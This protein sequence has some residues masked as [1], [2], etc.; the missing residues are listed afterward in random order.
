MSPVSFSD[1]DS[2]VG[3]LASWRS[4]AT[5]GW[6]GAVPILNPE[7]PLMSRET[8]LFQF[9]QLRPCVPCLVALPLPIKQYRGPPLRHPLAL[10]LLLSWPP[11]FPP[12][13]S[14]QQ[15]AA[16]KN[17]SLPEFHSWKIIQAN[18]L[19][20]QKALYSI[21]DGNQSASGGWDPSWDRELSTLQGSSFH[22]WAALTLRN[23]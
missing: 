21:P 1:H 11:S 20:V 15:A 10:S 7:P 9:S 3:P 4:W 8:W 5:W 18:Q 22:Y 12:P 19:L 23:Y 2:Y 16:L 6:G 13:P 17:G 14:T